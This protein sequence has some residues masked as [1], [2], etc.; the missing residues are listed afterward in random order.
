MT[1]AAEALRQPFPVT[2][3]DGQTVVIRPI[4]PDDAARLQAFHAR[5]SPESI[6]L[7]WLSAHPVLSEAE[8]RALSDVD[9]ARRMAFVAVCRPAGDGEERIVGVARYGV[10]PE[11]ADEA[12]AAVVVEDS[13]QSRGLGSALLKRLVQYSA[14]QGVR[15]WVAEINA[16]NARMLRFIQRVALP[17]TRRLEGGAWQVRIDISPAALAG[18][19]SASSGAQHSPPSEQ[20]SGEQSSGEQGSPPSLS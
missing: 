7:R 19:E 17:A 16:E 10:T 6:Y 2:L 3:A 4:R 14:A 18:A 12:E 1:A 20:S 11:R 15:A 13:Y 8:A 5:L 9:Y